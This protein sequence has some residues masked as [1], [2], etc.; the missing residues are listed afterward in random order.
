MQKRV[1]FSKR[2]AWR[3]GDSKSNTMK[4]EREVSWEKVDWLVLGFVFEL[5][6]WE[7]NPTFISVYFS[8]VL[9]Y[10][11]L[12]DSTLLRF[13]G[14]LQV[15]DSNPSSVHRTLRLCLP[16]WPADSKKEFFVNF[17]LAAFPPLVLLFSE[18]FCVAYLAVHDALCSAYHFHFV[19]PQ[20]ECH[21]PNS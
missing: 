1:N 4:P 10:S 13:T 2:I 16:I 18:T 17:L 19:H 11:K 21:H 3:T 9:D 12:N 7:R 8:S 5:T 20:C 14:Q 15:S 6:S